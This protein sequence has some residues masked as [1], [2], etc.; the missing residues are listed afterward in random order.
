MD[1]PSSL[2]T[3]RL[4]ATDTAEMLRLIAS[5]RAIL[6]TGSGFSTGATNIIGE[7]LPTASDLAGRLAKLG[8][9]DGDGDLRYV[10][11]R[12][13]ANGLAKAL[14]EQLK[15]TYTIKSVESF[16]IQISTAGWRRVYT[17]NYDLA[18]ERAAEQDGRIIE[19]VGIATS[20]R[21][22]NKTANMCASK[23]SHQFLK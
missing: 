20:H 2:T 9:F 7:R 23:R 22:P 17:T 19:T 12:L 11:D 8:N 3:D 4:A 14:I 1:L 13:I 6:F 18:V 5:G 10:A 16:H 21:D 15:N